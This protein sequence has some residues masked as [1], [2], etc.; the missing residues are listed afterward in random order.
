MP[1]HDGFPP[2]AGMAQGER[3]TGFA[4]SFLEKSTQPILKSKITSFTKKFPHRA[5]MVVKLA[6]F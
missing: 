5:H 4:G 1:A 3:K 2:P 6:L